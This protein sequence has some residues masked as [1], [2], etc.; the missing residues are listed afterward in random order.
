MKAMKMEK[1]EMTDLEKDLVELIGARRGA[2]N[3]IPRADLCA[4]LDNIGERKI[5]QAIKHLVVEHGIPI[6]SGMTGYYT[7]VTADEVWRACEY[8]HS[9]AMSCLTVESRLKRC[10]LPEILEQLKIDFATENTE[11]TGGKP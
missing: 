4:I 7:P 11:I 6:A 10:S 8:Y 3:A 9:Y 5:R 1:I 2:G